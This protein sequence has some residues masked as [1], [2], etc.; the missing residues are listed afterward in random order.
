MT[1]VQAP[2]AVSTT[3]PPRASRDTGVDFLRAL[4][5]LGVVLLHAIMVGVT[6]GESGPVFDNA[7]DESAWIAPLSWF[8]QVMPLFFVIGGFSG[9]LAYQRM[10]QRGGTAIGFVAGRVHRLL[11]PAILTIA[12]I[13]LAL[14]LL[15]VSGVPANLIATAGFRYG[16]PLWFLG[17]F[18]LCQALLPL[19]AASHERAP[20]R[21]IGALAVAA[22]AVDVLRAASGLEGLGFLNLAFVWMTLQQLGFFLADGSIDR[23]SRRVRAAAGIAALLTLVATFAFGIYSPDLIANMTIYVWHMPVL[24]L[25]AGSTAVFAL[26]TGMRL[27]ALDSAGWWAG[28]PLWLATAVALTALVAVAFTRFE[29][30][31]AP[32][33]TSSMR[34]LVVG[35]LSGLVG[36]VLLLALGTSVA[37]ALIAIA[38]IAA[39]LRLS[40]LSSAGAASQS[41]SPTARLVPA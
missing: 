1:I 3:A 24:L 32:P 10:R 28:R 2:R 19:L 15:T 36:I 4:C 25:M 33:A 17:V 16:Q 20:L 18:L 26:M 23:L 30:Q 27:P 5:V 7:S 39:S 21:T 8:L 40:S 29:S 34:R 13:G 6:V 22:I 35:T 12:V 38:L 14:A 41:A 9:L 11:R 37:T 31:P